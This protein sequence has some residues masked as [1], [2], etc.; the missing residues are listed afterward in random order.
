MLSL[1]PG[2]SRSGIT[3]SAMRALGYGRAAAVRMSFVIGVP[4][5]AGAGGWKVVGLVVDGVPDGLASAMLIGVTTAAITGWL[6]ITALQRLAARSDLN[7]FVL[8]RVALGVAVLGVV[9][10]GLR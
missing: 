4:I 6:A 3:M 8:Y 9:A 2:T 1:N 7:I 10:S 5:I